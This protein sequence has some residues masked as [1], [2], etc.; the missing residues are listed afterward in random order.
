MVW[1]DFLFGTVAGMGAM[2]LILKHIMLPTAIKEF[3]KDYAG[4]TFVEEIDG[5]KYTMK[6]TRS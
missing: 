2:Y 5:V 3:V 6:I 1:S 4:Q